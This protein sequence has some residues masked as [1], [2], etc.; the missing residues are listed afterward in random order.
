MYKYNKDDN[1]GPFVVV[2]RI[3]S[4]DYYEYYLVSDPSQER[5]F[6]KLI[7]LRKTDLWQYNAKKEFTELNVSK[8]L[9]N[10]NLPQLHGYGD[11]FENGEKICY[12]VYDYFQGLPLEQIVENGNL[13][14]IKRSTNVII[15]VLKGLDYIHSLQKP[16]IHNAISLSSIIVEGGDSGRAKLVGF[17]R[18]QF[19]DCPFSYREQSDNDFYVAPELLFGKMSPQSD[20]YSIGAVY[21]RLL[22]GRP[23][24]YDE[25]KSIEDNTERKERLFQI[26]NKSLRFPEAPD[27]GISQRMIT[28]L[29]SALSADPRFRPSSAKSFMVDLMAE[30]MRIIPTTPSP[31][32]KGSKGFAEIA[33]MEKL[34]EQLRNEVIDVL[35]DSE[36]ASALGIDIP[37]GLL[38]YG[39]PGCGKTYFAEKFAEELGSYFIYVKCSDVASPYIHGGQERIAKLFNEAREKA[40]S[41]IFLD[42]VEA[43]L[44]DRRKHDNISMAGEVNEF[45]A[46][47][48]NCGSS[49]V[50]V[51]GATNNPVILDPAALRAGRFDLKYYIPNPDFETRKSLFEVILKKRAVSWPIDIDLLAKDTQGYASVDIKTVVDNAGRYVFKNKGT[52]I[53]MPDLLYA[54]SVTKS[55]L[56]YDQIAQYESLKK[57]FEG[58]REGRADQFPISLS[59][60]LGNKKDNIPS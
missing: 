47:M 25:I 15:D 40:P 6:L 51:I 8:C 1:I 29:R 18:A 43:M 23:P 57:K 3:C 49:R 45:L 44:A 50:L 38:L 22:F 20:L 54:L 10:D 12:I 48:N 28:L 9:K 7:P 41:V 58:S 56:T 31:S 19:Q 2:D 35:S 24:F 32:I 52:T 60:Y 42:E 5:Y 4:G 36:R 39:P 27:K 55:S 59:Q 13:L 26:K 11:Y 16:I 34:K 46:Q 33:G 37:N 17:D 30:S 21:F 14:K 53:T